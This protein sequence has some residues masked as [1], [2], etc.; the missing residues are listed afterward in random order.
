MDFNVW[1]RIA[2]TGATTVTHARVPKIHTDA[3]NIS[4]VINQGSSELQTHLVSKH[5]K[6][7]YPLNQVL[8]IARCLQSMLL[9][10]MSKMGKLEMTKI[11]CTPVNVIHWYSNL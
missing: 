9:Q 7:F 5:L 3:D 1:C 10:V 6:V 4:F 11:L 8:S 2:L